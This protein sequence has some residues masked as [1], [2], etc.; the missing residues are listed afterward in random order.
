MI[1]NL[2][3]GQG[4]TLVT[5]LQL[6]R[7][8][9]VIATEGLNIKPHLNIEQY[10]PPERIPGVSQH[11]FEVVKRGMNGV[12]NGASGT[13]KSARIPGH[14]IAGKTGTA[15]NP[16]GADHKIFIAFAPYD[17]PGIAIACVTENT[18]DYTGSL[19]VKIVKHVLEDYFTYYPDIT[20]VKD[21]QAIQ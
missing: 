2:A 14:I 1:L 3:I 18:G 19:A 16:H 15:Q 20:V 12:I 8:T 11:S 4:E 6:A 17:D 9:G 21:D 13:A 5:V 10:E 7:Y